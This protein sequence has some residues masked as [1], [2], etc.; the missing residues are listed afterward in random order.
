MSGVSH[1]RAGG[2]ATLLVSCLLLLVPASAQARRIY[3]NAE[4]S[5]AYYA[6]QATGEHW[7][8]TATVSAYYRTTSQALSSGDGTL[9]LTP[10][11]TLGAFTARLSD[12]LPA[13]PINC[14]WHGSPGA[15]HQLA[16]LQDGTPFAH[17]LSI[18]WPGYPGLWD[19]SL[20]G[21]STPTCMLVFMDSPLQGSVTWALGRA[22]GTGGG[23]H[24]IFAAVPRST[25]VENQTSSASV[26][27]M[28]MRSLLTSSDGG[29][30]AV[31]AQGLLVESTVPFAGHTRVLPAASIAPGGKLAAP[32]SV[33]A[34]RELGL[35]LVPKR[36]PEGCVVGQKRRRHQRC[37]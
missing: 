27:G 6:S 29:S 11:A 3:I 14:T 18:Q 25:P 7:Q 33:N 17:A 26:A 31:A 22:S 12:P 30:H 5:Q 37:P 34:L 16:E 24:F 2:R 23:N 9:Q 21:S 28:T 8:S 36:V 35:R 19:Q 15:G 32:L 1:T 4:L 20:A 13:S 10:T